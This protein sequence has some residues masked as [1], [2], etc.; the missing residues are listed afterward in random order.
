MG[1]GLGDHMKQRGKEV[2]VGPAGRDGKGSGKLESSQP[3]ALLQGEPQAAPWGMGDT[4]NWKTGTRA[5]GLG[6]HEYG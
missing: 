4:L 3:S 6:R 1:W 2:R 5:E